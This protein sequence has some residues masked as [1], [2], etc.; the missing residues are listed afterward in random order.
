MCV[1]PSLLFLTFRLFLFSPLDPLGFD[2]SV[3]ASVAVF[4]LMIRKAVSFFSPGKMSQFP[5]FSPT[6]ESDSECLRARLVVVFS[7]YHLSLVALL[8][9]DLC[10]QVMTIVVESRWSAEG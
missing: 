8:M 4:M 1:W 6:L 3:L 9:Y 5:G 2:L 10:V 7:G